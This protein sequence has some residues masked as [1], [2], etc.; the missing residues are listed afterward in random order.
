MVVSTYQ[1]GN[2][3]GFGAAAIE[4]LELQTREIFPSHL[5]SS[6]WIISWFLFMKSNANYC[7]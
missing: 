1:A 2:S 4:E 3:A 5:I 7:I 6:S